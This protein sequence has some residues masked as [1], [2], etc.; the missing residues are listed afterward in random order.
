[1]KIKTLFFI[2]VLLAGTCMESLGQKERDSILLQNK[3]SPLMSSL[4][5][6][7]KGAR[8]FNTV[9]NCLEF[10]GIPFFVTGL[11]A[12]ESVPTIISF[13]LGFTGM[14]MSKYS[15]IPLTKA[16]R[17]LVLLRPFWKN[18]D[19]YNM[20]YHQVSTAE[21]L[22]YASMALAFGAQAMFIIGIIS[23]NGLD[24]NA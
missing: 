17:D 3:I 7:L 9:I 19:S 2:G 21:K 11:A 24:Y 18:M 14:E 15:P 22:S 4:Q 6:N 12:Q 5:S 8:T 13:A 10:I 1:M 23:D 20:I 16:R